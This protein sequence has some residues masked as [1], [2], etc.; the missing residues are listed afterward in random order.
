MRSSVVA[1]NPLSEPPLATEGLVL[2]CGLPIRSASGTFHSRPS[3]GLVSGV[4]C[5]F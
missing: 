5:G 4:C 2:P 1:W 3:F